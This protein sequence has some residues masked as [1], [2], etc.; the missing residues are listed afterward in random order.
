LIVHLGF[1]ATLRVNEELDFAGANSADASSAGGSADELTIGKGGM[2]KKLLCESPFAKTGPEALCFQTSKAVKGLVRVLRP[3]NPVKPTAILKGPPLLG[4]CDKLALDASSSY[5]SGGRQMLFELGLKPSQANDD[6]LRAYVAAQSLPPYTKNAWS[7]DPSMLLQGVPVTFVVRAINFLDESSVAELTVLKR[8]ITAPI[9]TI[10]GPR[11]KEVFSTATTR[12]R[13]DVVL[14]SCVT[15]S[16]RSVDFEWSLASVEPND[17]SEPLEL[18]SV[19]RNTRSLYIAPGDLLPGHNYTFQLKGAMKVNQSNFGTEEVMIVCQYAPLVAK[20]AGSNR[21][22][23]WGDVLTLDATSSIDL[24][25]EPQ[26]GAPV[27]NID[28]TWDCFTDAGEPCLGPENPALLVNKPILDL[29]TLILS[30]GSYTFQVTLM[31]EPGPRTSSASVEIWIA[32][33]VSPN[34]AIQPLTVRKVNPGA[35]LL[36]QGYLNTPPAHTMTEEALLAATA[37]TSPTAKMVWTQIDG[38]D[39]MQY[40]AKISTPPSLSSLAIKEGVLQCGQDYRFRF[41][42]TD[43]RYPA[44]QGLAE[45]AFRV[46]TPPSSGQCWV[47]PQSGYSDTNFELTCKDWVDDADDLP[48]NYEF[49]YMLPASKE[50]DDEIPL[51]TL[52][53]NLFTTGLPAPPAG[54]SR[55]DVKVVVYVTDQ[56]GGGART[57]TEAEVLQGLQGAS[58]G[59]GRRLLQEHGLAKLDDCVATG[60]VE[61]IIQVCTT[62]RL[63]CPTVI[64]P[65]QHPVSYILFHLQD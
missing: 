40:P 44:Q 32:P 34:A 14:S 4:P 47:S 49:R 53:K 36:L 17:L 50:P 62:C 20:L 13:G 19:T 56:S 9:I 26:P 63:S 27:W 48:L 16:D 3:P 22:I 46:N 11:S 51:G 52:D 45:I 65:L 8:D 61:C 38:E 29:D 35:R 37:L 60:N 43:S 15:E 64:I 1:G 39:I 30:P 5:G 24:D 55:H 28:Y 18:D 6:A 59:G 25:G 10:E 58:G 54:E 33:N 41:R 12:L 7:F 31:K 23:E 2:R 42:V 57:T 21:A